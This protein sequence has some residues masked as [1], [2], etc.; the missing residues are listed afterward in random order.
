MLGGKA[1]TRK[2]DVGPSCRR[3]LEMMQ[4]V[5]HARIEGL[6]VRDGRPVLTPAPKV[7][8]KVRM[9]GEHGPR[10][11]AMKDD[12]IL[13][14]AQVNFFKH[15]RRIRNGVVRSVEVQDGLPLSMEVETEPGQ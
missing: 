3:L 5:N 2:T 7:I 1:P 4:E 15:L 14:E 10:P 9:R 6:H 11:E 8:R 12:F 13:K